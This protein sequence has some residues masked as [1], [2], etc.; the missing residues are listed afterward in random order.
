MIEIFL[1]NILNNI[2]NNNKINIT[3]FAILIKVDNN[4]FS[5]FINKYKIS[6]LIILL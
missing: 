1:I 2:L 5:L 4:L 3:T 6:N